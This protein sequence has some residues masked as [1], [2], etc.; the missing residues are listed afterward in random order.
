MKEKNILVN[1]LAENLGISRTTLSRKLNNHVPFKSNE[2][3]QIIEILD[4][5][6]EDFYHSNYVI[7]D[8]K[9]Y[10]ISETTATEIRAIIESKGDKRSVK[11]I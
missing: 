7:L 11:A 3:K 6:Y 10:I 1:E 5:T 2:M 8:N 9:S 4:C